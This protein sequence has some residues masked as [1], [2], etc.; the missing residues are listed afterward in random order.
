MGRELCASGFSF[1]AFPAGMIMNF[2]AKPMKKSDSIPHQSF[3][4]E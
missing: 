3:K 4:H 2:F 1:L